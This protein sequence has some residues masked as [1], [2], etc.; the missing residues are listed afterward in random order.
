MVHCA[1]RPHETA[2]RAHR[3]SYNNVQTK[4]V[5]YKSF[6]RPTDTP[7]IWLNQKTMETYRPK[8]KAFYYDASKYNTYLEQLGIKYPTVK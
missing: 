3:S 2:A 6:L 7:A 5:K 1:A 4:D 8:M